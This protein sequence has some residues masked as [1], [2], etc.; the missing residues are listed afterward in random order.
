M[1][2]LCRVIFLL[3]MAIIL[4]LM[5][6]LL[7][8]ASAACLFNLRVDFDMVISALA[9]RLRGVFAI[10][11]PRI[12]VSVVRLAVFNRMLFVTGM[13]GLVGVN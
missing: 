1:R 8:F 6:S 11:R 2:H 4:T 5:G 10:R 7:G 13:P 3:T 9:I 12:R